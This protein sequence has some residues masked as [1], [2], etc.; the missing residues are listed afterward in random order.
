MTSPQVSQSY[1]AGYCQH[2][3]ETGDVVMH[4]KTSASQD[5]YRSVE[6]IEELKR[7]IQFPKLEALPADFLHQ[8]EEYCREAPRPLEEAAAA[9]KKVPY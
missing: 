3:A 4:M 6:Q 7:A 8:M 5:Y 9:A 2:S 1:F